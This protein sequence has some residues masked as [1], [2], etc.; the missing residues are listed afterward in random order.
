MKTTFPVTLT[1][2]LLGA[3]S[4]H[5]Q[6]E[7]VVMNDDLPPISMMQARIVAQERTGSNLNSHS[8]QFVKGRS[9]LDARGINA[10]DEIG[11]NANGASISIVG[12]PDS[13]NC[14]KGMLP[15]ARN[16]AMSMIEHLK[17]RG[18][19]TDNITIETTDILNCNL[20][21]EVQVTYKQRPARNLYADYTLQRVSAGAN[22]NYAAPI[23]EIIFSADAEKKAQISTELLNW[24]SKGIQSGEISAVRAI[25]LLRITS[26][27]E[28]SNE[29]KPLVQPLVIKAIAAPIA[30][31]VPVIQP[32]Q[33]ALA[34]PVETVKS[35]YSKLQEPNIT[36]WEILESDITLEKTF[37]RWSKLANWEVKWI[38]IPEI[39]N[40]GYV[41]ISGQ[42]FISV[43]DYVLSKAKN[44]AKKVG[45]DILI[46]AYSN[47]VLVISKE[48]QK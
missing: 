5:A 25:E 45:L 33:V 16:R 6:G 18:V 42:D 29:I 31:T 26:N 21:S 30:L 4:S 46:T 1:C 20:G 36:K 47:N 48:T 40:Q 13:A 9:V 43:S 12:R 28:S 7:Y 10:L 41:E 35:S 23:P 38:D 17:S 37:A 27:L 8:V 34:I 19:A 2:L 24:I 32:V 14:N 15:L 22:A 39:R 44:E 3:M 11:R